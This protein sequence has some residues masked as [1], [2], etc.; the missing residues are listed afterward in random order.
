MRGLWI[1]AIFLWLYSSNASAQFFAAQRQDWISSWVLNGQTEQQYAKQLKNDYQMRVRMVDRL[2]Q[3]EESQKSKLTL[4]ADADVTRFFREVAAIRKKVD[5]MDLEGNQNQDINK[6]WEVVSPLSQQ[7]QQ[8]LFAEKSLFQRVMRST[9]TEEQQGL[10]E[11]ELAENR[12]RRWQAITRV[13]LVEIE[14]SMP[15]LADQREKMLKIMDAQE[16]PKTITEHMDGYVG[17]LKLTKA[18]KANE[19]QFTEFLD[20][21]QMKVIE[22]FCDRYQGWAGN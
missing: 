9:L 21:H 7:L 16:L 14:R 17:F 22:Q 11:A 15:L 1:A 5:A 3:L 13:N 12:R 8:G 18:K 19:K 4:A 6:I 20:K 2:C 10:Y